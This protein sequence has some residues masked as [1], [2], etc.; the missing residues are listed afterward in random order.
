MEGCDWISN[1]ACD[2]SSLDMS[3]GLGQETSNCVCATYTLLTDVVL[4]MGVL[5]KSLIRFFMEDLLDV[6]HEFNL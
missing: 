5:E 4:G 1:R 6:L 2:D 3:R